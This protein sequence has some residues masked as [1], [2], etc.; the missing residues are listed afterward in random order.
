MKGSAPIEALPPGAL[1]EY[2]ELCGWALARA[3]AQSGRAAEIAGYLG[4]G[5]VFDE[6]I[7]RFAVAYAGQ[8]DIDYQAL[9]AAVTAGQLRAEPGAGAR[10]VDGV[11]PAV[12]RPGLPALSGVRRVTVAGLA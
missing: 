8:R 10:P 6:A 12:R 11:R 4:S 9:M 5:G 1:T 2:L 7:V 3:H